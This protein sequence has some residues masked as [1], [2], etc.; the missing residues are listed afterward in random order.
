MFLNHIGYD[1]GKIFKEL[2]VINYDNF[3][4]INI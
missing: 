1:V 4:F 2:K 3:K